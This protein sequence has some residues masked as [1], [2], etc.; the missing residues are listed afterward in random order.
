ML[1]MTFGEF[2]TLAE[3]DVGLISPPDLPNR[4]DAELG[5]ISNQMWRPI[6]FSQVAKDTCMSLLTEGE[7][8]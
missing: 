5:I 3:V 4:P 1:I 2:K 7:L 8:P 6:S